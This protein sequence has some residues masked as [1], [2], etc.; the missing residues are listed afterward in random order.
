MLG[1]G[2]AGGI[3]MGCFNTS[4]LQLVKWWDSEGEMYRCNDR[5]STHIN[6]FLLKGYVCY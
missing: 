4:L 5:N 3:M 2:N 6:L 1:V